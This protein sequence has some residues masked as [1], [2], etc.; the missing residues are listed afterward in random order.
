MSR[1][2]SAALLTVL[3]GVLLT[4]GGS[5]A[6]VEAQ[7]RILA[8]GQEYPQFD[9]ASIKANTSGAKERS[10]GFQPGFRFTA[11]NSSLRDLVAIAYGSLTPLRTFQ[12][13]GGPGWIDGDTFDVDANAPVEFATGGRDRGGL[14]TAGE[15][16]LRALLQDRFQL[17]AHAELREMAVYALTLSR[18]DGRSGAQL[19]TSSGFDCRDGSMADPLTPSGSAALPPCGVRREAAPNDAIR[20][21]ASGATMDQ[22]A[23]DLQYLPVGSIVIN[24]TGLAGRFSFAIDFA[25]ELSPPGGDGAPSIFTALQ[26]RLGLKLD[27]ARG[28]VDVLVIDRA[29]RP[30]SD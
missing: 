15:L 8:S 12:I 11:R 25:R 30:A 20:M 3:A 5:R 9:V 16:M 6:V 7:A 19:R 17:A 4:T 10:A 24:R 26:E 23:A 18:R 13:V 21:T 27:A 28:A 14:P 22:I 1:V 2:R 29:E